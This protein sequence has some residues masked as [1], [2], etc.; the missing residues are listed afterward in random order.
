MKLNTE[1]NN[2]QELNLGGIIKSG[3]SVNFK[4]G[5]WRSKVPIWQKENCIQCLNCWA[6]CPDNSVFIKDG[7][8]EQYDYNF[9]KGCGICAEECAANKKTIRNL[10]KT[11]PTKN[12]SAWDSSENNTYAKDAA[13]LMV[14]IEAAKNK[15]NIK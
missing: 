4:T 11:E 5:D 7:K 1:F 10:T 13:I 9:C 2:W 8:R 14:S 3:T 12:Y 6:F 15:Y